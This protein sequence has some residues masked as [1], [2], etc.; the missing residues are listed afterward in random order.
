MS[1][2]LLLILA[3]EHLEEKLHAK[4]P[5]QVHMSHRMGSFDWFSIHIGATV[6]IN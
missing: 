4:G 3:L 1:G 2:W 5:R 6:P